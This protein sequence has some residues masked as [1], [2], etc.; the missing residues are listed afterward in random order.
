M[1]YG[2]R[3]LIKWARFIHVYLTLFGFVLLLFFAVTG[4]L[5]NHEEWFS[6]EPHTYTTNGVVPTRSLQPLDKLTVVE[7]LRANL[8]VTGKMVDFNDNEE[9]LLVVFEGPGRRVEARIYREDGG[10]TTVTH[11]S[12]GLVGILTDLHKGKNSGPTWGL[13]IDGV[14][15]LFVIVSLTGLI[16]WSS[17]RSRGKYGSLLIGLGLGIS[18]WVYFVFVP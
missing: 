5:L 1:T 2:H 3:L 15:I 13:V 14:S 4:F 12:R 8:G 16:L 10:R 6:S 7:T 18:L 9:P 11:E 17:L